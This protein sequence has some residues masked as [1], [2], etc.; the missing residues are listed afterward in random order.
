MSEIEQIKS[1]VKEAE[2]Y[3]TQ[4]LFNQSKEKYL[5][6]I[7]FIKNHKQLSNEKKLIDAVN[8]K[9]QAIEDALTEIDQATDTPQLSED[10]QNLISRLFSSSKNKEF[11]H[12]IVALI[13]YF[14]LSANKGKC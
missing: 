3:R 4:G 9:I 14:F 2:I 5:E 7:Q 1:M 11:S 13:Y 6:L 12:L 10:L 8:K